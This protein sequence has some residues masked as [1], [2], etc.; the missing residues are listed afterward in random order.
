MDSVDSK[1]SEDSKWII[2]FGNKKAHVYNL[3]CIPMAGSGAT[4]YRDWQKFFDFLNVCPIQ[5]PG[6]ENRITEELVDDPF[7][8]VDMMYEGIK[9]MLDMPFSIFGHSMGGFL[10]YE[11]VKKIHRETGRYPVILFIS[12]TSLKRCEDRKGVGKYSD[13]ELADYLIENGGTSE[14]LL[15]M[16]EFREVYFPIIRNDYVLV[17]RYRGNGEKVGCPVRALASISDTEVPVS[18]TSDIAAVSDDF[19]ITYFEGGH[20]YIRDH[21]DRVCTYVSETLREAVGIRNEEMCI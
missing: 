19:K 11:L 21:Y 1:V 16:E 10:A 12:A 7:E 3:F 2:K 15:A 5:L 14:E 8:L 6:R 4:L 20:F 13:S 17:D 18:E 9:G